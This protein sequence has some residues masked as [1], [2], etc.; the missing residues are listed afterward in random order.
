M[1]YPLSGESGLLTC[2]ETPVKFSPPPGGQFAKYSEEARF[3][4]GRENKGKFGESNFA[5]QLNFILSLLCEGRR[6]T[7]Q[8]GA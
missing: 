6:A 7:T 4:G 2:E 8:G 1:R 5:P 3:G